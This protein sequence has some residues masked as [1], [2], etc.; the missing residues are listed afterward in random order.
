MSASDGERGRVWR[1]RRGA[2]LV[3]AAA[4][5]VLALG[6]SFLPTV[7]VRY[8]LWRL[9][10]AY[11]ALPAGQRVASEEF[12][13]VLHYQKKLMRMGAVAAEPLLRSRHEQDYLWYWTTTTIVGTLRS[14]QAEE[15][16]LADT[17][18]ADPAVVGQA[19]STLGTLPRLRRARE[20]LRLL[21][22]PSAG[23]R[24]AAVRLVTTQRIREAYPRVVEMLRSDPDV[25]VRA[26]AAHPVARLG[27]R[28]AIPLLIEALDDPGVTRTGPRMSVRSAARFWL[29]SL[30]GE[31]L[32]HKEDWER[33][34]Q[35]NRSRYGQAAIPSAVSLEPAPGAVQTD[36]SAN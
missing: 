2:V 10:R 8:Y 35:A 21:S 26:L 16:L 15:P 27:G 33:W 17:R 31:G 11:R 20:V 19:L 7:R 9:E 29:Q 28:K 5:V 3:A 13:A 25:V 23:V 18:S 30:T 6:F 22:H 36:L 14:A 12:G 4:L 32:A 34:W 1:R 24:A